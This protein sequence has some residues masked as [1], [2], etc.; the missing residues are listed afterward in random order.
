[1]FVTLFY[2][3]IDPATGVMTYANAG[4]NSPYL[5]GDDGAVRALTTAG[6][7]ALGVFD[8]IDYGEASVEIAPDQTLVMFT[9]GV[10]EAMDPDNQEYGEARLEALLAACGGAAPDRVIARIEDDVVA[11]ASGAPQADDLT[12]MAIR[13]GRAAAADLTATLGTDLTQIPTFAKRLEVWGAAT[14]LSGRD[15]HALTLSLDELMT[16]AIEYGAPGAPETGFEM[17]V[18]LTRDGDTVTATL[19]DNGLAFDPL[20]AAAPD[21]DSPP[22]QREVGGLGVHFA[23]TLT[24][25]QRYRRENGLNVLTL[26]KSLAGGDDP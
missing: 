23:K 16:N 10:T 1:M 13:R 21:L 4:H 7:P 8:D 5:V 9:D 17:T 14:G 22:D 15:I 25:S 3:V 19:S 26:T 20:G 6:G 12:M 18:S 11:F 24:D 2:G